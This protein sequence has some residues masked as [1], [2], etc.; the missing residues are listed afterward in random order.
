MGSRRHGVDGL[1]WVSG[2]E[3]ENLEGI[4]GVDFLSLREA[5]D[6]MLIIIF[7]KMTQ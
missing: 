4:P 7:G 6:I 3:G 1:V 2:D 5:R